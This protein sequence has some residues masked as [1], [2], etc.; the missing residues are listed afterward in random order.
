MP[1]P[2]LYKARRVGGDRQRYVMNFAYSGTG[3]FET[4]VMLPNLTTQIGFFEQLIN[5]G[6]Y[7]SSDLRS[8]MALVS[9]STNDY[10]FYL[11]RKGTL[12]GL[13][14]F[15]GLVVNQTA[16]NLRRLSRLGV[17][18]IAILGL[19][20]FGCFTAIRQLLASAPSSCD[21]LFNRYSS[22]HNSLLRK[23]VD[24]INAELGRPSHVVMLDTY[25]AADSIMRHHNELGPRFNDPL[26]P[27]CMGLNSSTACGSVDVQGMP[28]YTVCR[29]PASA[30]FWDLGHLTQAGSSA[31]FRYYLPTLHQFFS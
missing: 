10:S 19:F 7:R 14:E 27:C 2:T 29:S 8:S 18:K 4:V 1:S 30:F 11:L 24:D 31:M 9:A 16:V 12:E 15:T 23:A 26:K 20:P 3:V 22:Q 25:S 28:L 21:D 17:G 6:T 13:N 5:G